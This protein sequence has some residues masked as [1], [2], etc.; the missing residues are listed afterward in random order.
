LLFLTKAELAPPALLLTGSGGRTKSGTILPLE[1]G[2][3][4][5]RKME[6]TMATRSGGSGWLDVVLYDWSPPQPDILL[7]GSTC[8]PAA[9]AVHAGREDTQAVRD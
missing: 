8:G 3:S 5:S 9:V 7:D 6:A 4:L 2:H 1:P